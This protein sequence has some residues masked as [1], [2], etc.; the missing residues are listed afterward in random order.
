MSFTENAFALAVVWDIGGGLAALMVAVYRPIPGSLADRAVDAGAAKTL[1]ELEEYERRVARREQQVRDE[2]AEQSRTRAAQVEMEAYLQQREGELRAL[3]LE[4]L[5]ELGALE[6]A[7]RTWVVPVTDADFATPML[8]S[9]EPVMPSW[10]SDTSIFR[11]ISATVGEQDD[12]EVAEDDALSAGPET[13]TGEPDEQAPV[14]AATVE[15]QAGTCAPDCGQCSCKGSAD[16][17]CEHCLSFLGQQVREFGALGEPVGA[18][19]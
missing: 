11:A 5:A 6:E 7:R 8:P 1:L 2:A 15:R 13:L 12:D 16:T 10:L 18:D 19:R 17:A 3:S 9:D 14:P 4:V